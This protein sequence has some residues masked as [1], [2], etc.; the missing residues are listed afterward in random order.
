MSEWTP[1]AGATPQ[2]FPGQPRDGV[3]ALVQRTRDAALEMRDRFNNLLKNAGIR[4]EPGKLIIEGDLEVPNGSIKNAYLESPFVGASGIG[5]EGTFEITETPT[6]RATWTVTV[7][8]GYT[9]GFFVANVSLQAQNTAASTRYAYVRAYIEYPNA[10]KSWGS[11]S[12]MTLAAG[13]SGTAAGHIA[14]T[15]TEPLVGGDVLTFWA[16]VSAT[17]GSIPSDDSNFASG[18]CMVLFTR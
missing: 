8:A 15:L 11:R 3:A 14:R 5:N 18:D 7:P 10:V 17:G 4:V 2:D 1:P 13:F 16:E 6:A 12:M 9:T